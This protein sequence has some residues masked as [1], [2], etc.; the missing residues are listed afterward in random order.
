METVS[1]SRRTTGDFAVGAFTL[2][3]GLVAIAV[4]AFVLL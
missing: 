1:L 2:I 3:G 4:V